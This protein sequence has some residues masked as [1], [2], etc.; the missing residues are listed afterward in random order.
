MRAAKI[1]IMPPRKPSHQFVHASLTVLPFAILGIEWE[2][3]GMIGDQRRTCSLREL[4]RLSGPG[5]ERGGRIE[6]ASPMTSSSL[7]AHAEFTGP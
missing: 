6:I 4:E 5:L 2:I 1:H 3:I 7:V